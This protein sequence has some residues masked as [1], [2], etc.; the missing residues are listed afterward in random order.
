MQMTLVTIRD[1]S[2]SGSNEP[3][4]TFYFDPALA[5]Q[6]GWMNDEEVELELDGAKAWKATIGVAS[7]GAVYARTF[8][9]RGN[10][11][12]R[13]HSWIVIRGL[14][15]MARVEMLVMSDHRLRWSQLASA[16]HWKARHSPPTWSMATL[17][18]GQ[19]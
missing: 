10:E 1:Y 12:L 5:S 16:G 2:T 19:I 3:L 8:L 18:N 13:T 14:A 17:E 7:D 9:S 4:F 15:N 11:Q 6:C